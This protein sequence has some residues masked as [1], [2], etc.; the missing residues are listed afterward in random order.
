MTLIH[1]TKTRKTKKGAL[2]LSLFSLLF[3]S[4]PAPANELSPLLQTRARYIKKMAR[5]PAKPAL[6]LVVAAVVAMLASSTMAFA[7]AAPSGPAD[8]AVF[9]NYIIP[10]DVDGK[11]VSRRCCWKGL[12]SQRLKQGRGAK[13]QKPPPLEEEEKK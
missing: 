1:K 13:E 12:E 11:P 10:N 5:F 3:V 7:A 2:S 9:T 6:L 4:Q 8:N